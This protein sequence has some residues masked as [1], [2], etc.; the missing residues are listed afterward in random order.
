MTDNDI[1]IDAYNGRAPKTS[2]FSLSK[3]VSLMPFAFAIR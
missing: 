1:S 2:K 3:K